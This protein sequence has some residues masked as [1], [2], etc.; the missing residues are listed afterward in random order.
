MDN[1][2]L[3]ENFI[4]VG[5]TSIENPT[6]CKKCGSEEPYVYGIRNNRK[7][8]AYLSYPDLKPR[9]RYNCSKCVALKNL[10]KLQAKVSSCKLYYRDCEICS[11]VFTARKDYGKYC[12]DKCRNKGSNKKNYKRYENVCKGCSRVFVK[13]VRSSYCS[14]DC[15]S[16]KVEKEC[17]TCN[18]RFSGTPR[19]KYCSPKCSPHNRSVRTRKCDKCDNII[20]KPKKICEPCKTKPKPKKSP[21]I[22]TKT[23][24]TCD[25]IFETTTKQKVYCKSGHSPTTR[26]SGKLHKRQ[27]KTSVRKARLSC[28][29]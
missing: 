8:M 20:E 16:H 12:G 24:P 27:R 4:K 21:K 28:E 23:C 29:P 17:K 7:S 15:K 11:S 19:E 10:K 26:E 14:K 22:Y 2:W 3:K 13:N 6:F 1:N 9:S 18:T 25:Q 5:G